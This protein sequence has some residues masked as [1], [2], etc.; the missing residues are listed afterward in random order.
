MHG[1]RVARE[2]VDREHVEVLRRLA[3]EVQPRVAQ[4][5]LDRRVAVLQV[6]EVA[7]AMRD[8]RGI[9]VVEAVD[10]ALRAVGRERAGAEADHADLER[11]QASD[12]ALRAARPMPEVGV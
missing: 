11:R 12:A 8:H 9:D 5:D 1:D 6:R 4:R 3:L 10:V 2:R 7:C